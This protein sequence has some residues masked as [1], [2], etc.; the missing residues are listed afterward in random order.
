MA[1][2]RPSWPSGDRITGD[3]AGGRDH[4]RD[5]RHHLW[6]LLDPRIFST[7]EA[8]RR[9]PQP[10]RDRHFIR[11]TKEEMVGLDGR[12][13]YRE[14]ACDTFSYTLG[15]GPEGEQALY[16]LTT[17]YLR[18][19]YNRPAVRLAMS[20]FQRRLASSTWALLRS[21]ERRIGKLGQTI[22]DLQSGRMDAAEFARRQ[23]GLDREYR[24]DFFD[25]HGAENDAPNTPGIRDPDIRNPYIRIA[26]TRSTRARDAGANVGERNESYEDAVLGAVIAV[27]VEELRQEI[28]TFEDLSACARRLV[29]SGRLHGPPGR[30]P[31]LLSP[32]RG[33]CRAGVGVR[34]RR[35]GDA[36]PVRGG[37]GGSDR[38]GCR[39]PE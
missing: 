9:F 2:V 4:A 25:V 17:A 21:F 37:R 19:V 7:A 26:G 3:L 39:E 20:V 31:I 15:P 12:P 29:E 18:R 27:T 24:E 38:D 34:A 10:E 36:R 30:C 14:R 8:L 23:R 5:R 1:R 28:D 6:R 33:V 11:R 16:E 22:D 35:T 32:R 13:L